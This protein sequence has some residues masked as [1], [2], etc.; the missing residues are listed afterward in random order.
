MDF[1]WI[2]RLKP[3]FEHCRQRLFIAIADSAALD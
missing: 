2:D 1:G 3:G